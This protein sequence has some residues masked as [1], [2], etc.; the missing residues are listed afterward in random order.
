MY[1]PTPPILYT[2]STCYDYNVTGCCYMCRSVMSDFPL[3]CRVLE[4]YQSPQ[5]HLQQTSPNGSF[6]SNYRIRVSSEVSSDID[7][8]IRTTTSYVSESADY[9]ELDNVVN[10]IKAEGSSSPKSPLKNA[11]KLSRSIPLSSTKPLGS[12][13]EEPQESVD[14]FGYHQITIKKEH[15]NVLTKSQSTIDMFDDP[16]Y[17]QLPQSMN[18]DS[19]SLNG[20]L[21]TLNSTPQ[22]HALTDNVS[23]LQSMPLSETSFDKKDQ[24]QYMSLDQVL[25][26]VETRLRSSSRETSVEMDQIEE[27]EGLYCPRVLRPVI[28]EDKN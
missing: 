13:E 2:P 23:Q 9:D 10:A 25:Q 11:S 15:E 21:Q 16:K 5:H 14:A 18:I 1:A 22:L 17:E 8:S 12:V 26:L 7:A 24:K 3:L 19:H 6:S 20:N 4:D 27:N 28:N